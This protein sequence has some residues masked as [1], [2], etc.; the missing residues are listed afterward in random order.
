MATAEQAMPKKE[1][2]E[3]TMPQKEVKRKVRH[4]N[5]EPKKKVQN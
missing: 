2:T 5:D 1:V 4:P 3:G